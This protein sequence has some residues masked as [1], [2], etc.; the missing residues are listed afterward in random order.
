MHGTLFYR[1]PRAYPERLPEGEFLVAA[2]PTLQANQQGGAAAWLQLMFP[3]IGSLGSLGMILV[4][5][6]SILIVVISIGIALF[7]VVMG[8]VMR[9]QQQRSE[10]HTS[11]LQSR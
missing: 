5:H 9:L 11:E 10:E 6:T 4:F 3:L 2:P 1:P 7:S 8:L